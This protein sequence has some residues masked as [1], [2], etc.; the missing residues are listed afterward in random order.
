MTTDDKNA[1]AAG[2]SFLAKHNLI[3][4]NE[5]D[6]SAAN[7]VAFGADVQINPAE[8]PEDPKERESAKLQRQKTMLNEL[9]EKINKTLETV[10]IAATPTAR[11]TVS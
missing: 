7:K 3:A 11:R 10:T 4:S 9:N 5:T 8:L 2:N 6:Q 1:L